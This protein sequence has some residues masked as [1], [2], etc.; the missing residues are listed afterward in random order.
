MIDARSIHVLGVAGPGMSALARIL[1]GMGASVSG[2]DTRL[3]EVTHRLER[4]GVTVWRGNDERHVGSVDVLTH[5]S[6][7]SPEHPEILAARSRGVEVLSRAQALA[8]VCAR[9]SSIGVAGT[10]GK[11][12]TTA[13]LA[14]ILI[15][16]GRDPSYLIGGETSL[17]GSNAHWGMGDQFV[18]EAD[19]S[20][21]THVALPL[22]AGMVTNVDVDHLDNFG[23]FEEIQRSFDRFVEQ[24]DGPVLVCLDD[25]GA[26]RLA[27]HGH[28]VG[29][30]ID[31][32]AYRATEIS[33]LP[34][35]LQFTVVHGDARQRVTL[36]QRGVHNVRNALGAIAMAHRL[37]VDL[38]DACAGVATFRG[39]QRRFDVRG[40][41]R[42]VT[43]VDD[44]AHL[45]A[46]IVATL[47]AAKRET[48][49]GRLVAVFQPN[50]FNRMDKMSGAYCDSFVAADVAV[51]TEIYA[52]GTTPIDGVSGRLVVDAVRTAHPGS[53][54]QWCASRD[55]VL[56]Y[57]DQVLQPGDVCVSMGCGDIEQLPA[58]M[59]AKWERT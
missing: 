45:P 54:V 42:G 48:G 41:A 8:M 53:V 18:V 15:A 46:E 49:E 57:L 44:Y 14:T 5:S 47:E 30:G 43:F 52:S 16:S 37:G 39:V 26:A 34:G 55:D 59:M 7:I 24:V 13:M 35:R 33:F 25:Q 10:H 32:G 36:A 22:S 20:D 38:A 50:R 23:T 28:V 51:V 19:E 12:T 9:R 27:R 56:A 2:C 17:P 21:S 4:D 6:A 1:A 11:T 31:A 40:T 29:Y 3:G 58:E